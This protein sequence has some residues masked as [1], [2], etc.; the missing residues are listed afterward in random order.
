MLCIKIFVSLS[1]Y[2][3]G[4]KVRSYIASDSPQ[5]YI[6][7]MF[8]LATAS[9]KNH[10]PNGAVDGVHTDKTCFRYRYCSTQYLGSCTCTVVQR[11]LV[12]FTG[13]K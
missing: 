11:D 2:Y 4:R 1:A 5:Y 13:G 9:S 12:E 10:D 3:K 8:S 6:V 7:T